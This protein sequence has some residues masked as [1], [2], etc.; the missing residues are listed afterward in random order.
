M[1]TPPDP[2]RVQQIF[3]AAAE[4]PAAERESFLASA[5]HDDVG[6][7]TEVKLLMQSAEGATRFVLPS[8]GGGHADE[9]L[10]TRPG[11]P[12]DVAVIHERPGT[13]IGPYKLLEQIG[14]GGFGAVFMAEQEKPVQRRVALKIIKL[15][16]DTGQ[17]VARFEQERQA[18]AMMDHPNIA[19]VLDA[20]A[21]DTGR[22]YFVMELCKG[23]S[24]TEYCDK[25]NL[26][27]RERLA[28]FVQVCLAVQH[29]HQKGLI[30]RDIKPSNILVTTQD[31]KPHAKVIDFGI[32]KATASKLTEKT[33]FTEHRQLIG[34]PEYMSPEQAEGSLDIDTRT[35]VYSL[36]VLLYE[37]LTGSTPFDSKKLRSAAFGEIQRIIR[38]VDP[39]NPST[40]LSQSSA[41]LIGVAA[42]RHSE[43]RKLNAI[44]RGELDWIVM[45]SLEKNRQR[46]YSTAQGLAADV[47]RYLGGE[48]IVAAP[49]GA[50]YRVRKFVSRHRGPVVAAGLVGAALIAGLAGTLWQ[51]SN[52]RSERDV[53]IA[54]KESETQARQAAATL[55]ASEAKQR[56]VAESNERKAEAIN[57]FLLEMLGSADV[58]EMGRDVKVSEALV[59]AAEKAGVTLKDQPEVEAA[60]RRILGST[61][62]S[63]GLPD[64]AEPEVLAAM[65]LSGKLHGEDSIDL[66]RA[67]LVLAKLK[68]QRGDFAASA[69]AAGRAAKIYAMLLGPNDPTTLTARGQYA[70]ALPAIGK[71]QESVDVLT[72]VLGLTTKAGERESRE[73]RI[74]VNSLAVSY[75]HL[76]KLDEAEALYREAVDISARL[77]GPEHPDTLTTRMNLASMLQGRGNITEAEPMMAETCALVRK[78]FGDSHTTTATAAANLGGLYEAKGKLKD[79]LP[80]LEESLD[81]RRRA[82]GESTRGVALAKQRVAQVLSRLGEHARAVAMQENSVAVYAIVSGAEDPQTLTARVILANTLAAA[83]RK[84]EAEVIYTDLLSVCPRVLGEDHRTTIISIN[85][86]G[87]LLMRQDRYAEA[88]PFV[89]KALEAGRRSQEA[90]SIDT[91][92]TQHNLCAILREAGKVDEAETLGRDT[93]EHMMRV[94]GPSHP[95]IGSVRNSYGETLQKLGRIAEA[96]NELTLAVSICK[97]ALGE[98]HANTVGAMAR[99]GSV[100]L[101]LDDAA[102]AESKLRE[103]TAVLASIRGDKDTRTA[104]ARLDLGRALTMLGKHA[105]AEPLL[106]ENHLILVALR[107]PEHKDIFK[108]ERI[109]ATMYS[110]WNAAEPGKGHH[111]QAAE[112]EAK[113]KQQKQ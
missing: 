21:T 64:A 57:T 43:P 72:D 101:D 9:T 25:H 45:K 37:L 102:G 62:L 99:L 23:E 86:Y 60:V 10:I 89:R 49:P 40:R 52:A 98:K 16:M 106:N 38:E 105:E 46:R 110:A 85:S 59:R 53:A 54:A 95:N 97:A 77:D 93:L 66:A 88:E 71:A 91:L 87:V 79:A 56:Q 1:S 111:V 28:L 48:A 24:I 67:L 33:L 55:A 76:G 96:K 78:V 4:L 18:L 112:W 81:T 103:A 19:K 68:G 15:G 36:G 63:L 44:I 29:A 113:V 30:H 26:S 84:A 82:E 27:I 31:D 3:D 17:V 22:P 90:D 47:E 20:G 65:T 100:M 92:T 109:L 83:D 94:L 50:A 58:R 69:E 12:R 35:D 11:A 13:R 70:I 39:P 34:T 75:H 41:T 107:A 7:H 73:G 61:F 2:K 108:A 8:T 6:L 51:A 80:L 32:A 74:M 104:N 5:C 42:A 14:E